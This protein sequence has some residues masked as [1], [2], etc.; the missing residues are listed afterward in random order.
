V[1]QRNEA[2]RGNAVSVGRQNGSSDG[3]VTS[4]TTIASTSVLSA[5]H[6]V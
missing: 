4:S 2:E 3:L 1:H 5:F 6:G